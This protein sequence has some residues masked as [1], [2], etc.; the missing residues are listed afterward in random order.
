[1]WALLGLAADDV[2]Q[3]EIRVHLDHISNWFGW[4][5]VGIAVFMGFAFGER[6]KYEH[7]TK[8]KDESANKL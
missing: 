1:L 7:E 4:A 8:K 6:M 3:P 5:F 2:T